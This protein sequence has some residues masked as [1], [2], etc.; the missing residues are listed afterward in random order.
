M[1]I[2]P[3]GASLKIHMEKPHMKISLQMVD[4]TS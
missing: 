3:G 1:T 2:N 4:Q